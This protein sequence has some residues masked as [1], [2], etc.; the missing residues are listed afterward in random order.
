MSGKNIIFDNKKINKSNFYKSKKHDIDANK[1]LVSKKEPYG[2][3]TSLKYFFGYN[4]DSVI[5]PSCIKLGYV[6]CFDSNMT[7]SFKAT[8]K[9]LLKT[10]IKIWER[11]SS[12]MN[13][14][15]DS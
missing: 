9:K 2:A 12:L 5:R 1:I 15:F 8:D 3:K 4:N 14:E 6:K 13:T 7:M 10:Y 11:V